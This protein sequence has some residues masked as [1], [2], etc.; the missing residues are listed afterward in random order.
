[1]LLKDKRVNPSARD[2]ECLKLAVSGDYLEIV[3]VLCGNDRVDP[4]WALEGSK[5]D[6]RK[7]LLDEVRRRKMGG[8][9]D[10]R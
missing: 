5:G 6:I 3:K 1:M 2:E 7:F 10:S 9:N 4:S 8:F